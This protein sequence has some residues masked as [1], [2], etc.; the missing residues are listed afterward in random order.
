MV[1]TPKEKLLEILVVIS[2]DNNYSFF[3]VPDNLL[4]EEFSQLSFVNQNDS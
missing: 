1:I 2:K 4:V 3:K